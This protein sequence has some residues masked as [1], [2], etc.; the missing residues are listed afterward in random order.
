[1]GLAWAY[2]PFLLKLKRWKAPIIK[3]LDPY[4]ITLLPEIAACIHIPCI[5]LNKLNTLIQRSLQRSAYIFSSSRIYLFSTAVPWCM[6]SCYGT[7]SP[8]CF[9][10]RHLIDNGITQTS[11]NN[12]LPAPLQIDIYNSNLLRFCQRALKAC[13][14]IFLWRCWF[15]FPS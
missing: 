11:S 15:F 8:L 3:R 6:R 10:P 1:M 5:Y 7:L 9:E 14:N 2:V 13:Y 12:D 4:S